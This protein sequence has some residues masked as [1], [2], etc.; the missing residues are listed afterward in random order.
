VR[1]L[2]AL[3]GAWADLGGAHAAEVLDKAVVARVFA[4]A[5]KVETSDRVPQDPSLARTELARAVA[6]AYA[7][8]KAP[9]AAW[10]TL[11]AS[12]AGDANAKAAATEERR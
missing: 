5:P 1:T 4:A 11:L 10:E 12:L 7:A 9:P 3:V 6:R 2:A 8:E